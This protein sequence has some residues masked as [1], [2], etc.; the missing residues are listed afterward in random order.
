MKFCSENFTEDFDGITKGE[1][2]KKKR[3]YFLHHDY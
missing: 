1:K 3:K 2:F